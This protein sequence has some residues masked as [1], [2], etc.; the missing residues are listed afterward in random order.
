MSTPADHN[1]GLVLE[2]LEKLER[3]SARSRPVLAIAILI[4]VLSLVAVTVLL[5]R[6]VR[7]AEQLEKAREQLEQALQERN[8]IAARLAQYNKVLASSDASPG[9]VQAARDSSR[10]LS[11]A[12][13]GASGGAFAMP[14]QT[15]VPRVQLLTVGAATGWD[16]D[17]FWCDGPGA[18]ESYATGRAASIAL[19]TSAT[20]TRP[21]APGV[22]LGRVQLRSIRP[23]DT[24]VWRAAMKGR[25]LLV[26]TDPTNGEV[27]AAKAIVGKILTS[28]AVIE[29]TELGT[30]QSA[31]RWYLSVVACPSN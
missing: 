22:R 13:P 2:T 16:L 25:N 23:E 31:T 5:A 4:A 29:Q 8:L 19:A 18:P 3:R 20:A 1:A 28:A 27:E 15:A 30:R 10:A 9:A 17:V 11:Q 12:L 7:Q 14:S 26:V 24:G 21:I 6:S